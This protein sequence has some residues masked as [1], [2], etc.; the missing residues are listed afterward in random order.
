M[1]QTGFGRPPLMVGFVLG[2]L[3]ERYLGL[4]IQLYGLTWLWHPWVVVIEVLIVLTVYYGWKYQKKQ[5][6]KPMEKVAV[7]DKD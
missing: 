3:G 2:N 7:Q 6:E 1:K 4:T 5:Y